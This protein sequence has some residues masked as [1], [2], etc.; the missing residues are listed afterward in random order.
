MNDLSAAWDVRIEAL[1]ARLPARFRSAVAW[2]R[3]PSRRTVRFGAAILLI[4]GGIFSIL[5]VLGIWMLPLGLAL[6]AEDAP[7]LK[8]QLERVARWCE[9]RWQAWTARPRPGP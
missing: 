9:R 2:L 6:L 5:P 3:E 1:L 7:G 4:I 8:P